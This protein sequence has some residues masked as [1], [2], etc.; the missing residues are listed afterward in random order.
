MAINI[1]V[2]N[3]PFSVIRFLESVLAQMLYPSKC[4]Q[5]GNWGAS[6]C[7]AC[8]RTIDYLA[9]QYCPAC[10]SA[11]VMGYKNHGCRARSPIDQLYSVCWYRGAV[12]SLIMKMKFRP[13]NRQTKTFIRAM[14]QKSLGEEELAAWRG[15]VV[16]PIP[17]STG[18]KNMRGF[19]QAELIAL[20]VAALIDGTLKSDMLLR[21]KYRKSQS[22]MPDVNSRHENIKGA[23]RVAEEYTH[24]EMPAHIL[25]ID[26]VYTSGSTLTECARVIKEV[27]PN[28][29]VFAFTLARG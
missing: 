28:V 21:R 13:Y 27:N 25:L 6:M 7:D 12:R 8:Q 14:L 15:L 22:L 17:L 2:A 29:R 4:V 3:K 16:V 1:E 23:F 19:N 26:D 18:R 20:E 5:C 11:S 9:E 10:K 24:G